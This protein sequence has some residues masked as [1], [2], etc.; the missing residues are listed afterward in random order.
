MP[1]E[2]L[3][4]ACLQEV[5]ALDVPERTREAL[6]NF[7]ANIQGSPPHNGPT[8]GGSEDRVAGVLRLIAAT[9]EFSAPSDGGS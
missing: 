3:V 4:D 2:N 7:A 9:P 8:N 6:V 5:G 1:P